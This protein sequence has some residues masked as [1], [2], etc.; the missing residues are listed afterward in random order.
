MVKCAEC[1]FLAVRNV[2][3]RELEEAEES[4]REKGTG[5][6]AK[7][8]EGNPHLRH[9]KQPQCFAMVHSLRDDFKKPIEQKIPENGRVK[10]VILKEREC[11]EFTKWQ[12]GSTP[13][14]HR[15]MLDRKQWLDWQAGREKDDRNFRTQ[16]SKSNRRYRIIELILVSITIIVIL[17][18]AFIGRGEPTINIITP[19]PSEVTIEQ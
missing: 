12:Q 1:G 8:Y 4:F 2:D 9:E 5:P 10:Q 14:E 7:Q 17:L 11:G 3:S 15:E 6:L 13:K 16:E 18:T 19:N